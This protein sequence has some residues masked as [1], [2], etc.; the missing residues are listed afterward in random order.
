MIRVQ[1]LD[2]PMICKYRRYKYEPELD[3][4][5]VWLIYGFD[6]EYGKFLRAKQQVSDFLEKVKKTDPKVKSYIDQLHYAHTLSDLSAYN[7]LIRYLRLTNG[8][9]ASEKEL[10]QK[11]K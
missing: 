5:A 10:S 8:D 9:F 1:Y 7:A 3:E 6:L 2:I 4:E 11:R